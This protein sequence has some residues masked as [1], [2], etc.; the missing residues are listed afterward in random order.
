MSHH[1]RTATSAHW[2]CDVCQ[3]STAPVVGLSAAD[4]T[5]MLASVHDR[6]HHGGSRTARLLLADAL[7][8]I[9]PVAS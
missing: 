7:P 5:A 8:T 9:L 4:E 2:S 3:L 6:I 1:L